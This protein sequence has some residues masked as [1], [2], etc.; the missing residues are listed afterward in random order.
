M[1]DYVAVLSL[2]AMAG[3][4]K[5][6]IEGPVVLAKNKRARHEYHI[7][8]VFEAGIV[9]GSSE[10]KSIRAGQCSITEAFG[11]I[12]DGEVWLMGMHV[13]EY[14]EATFNNHITRRNRKLLLHNAEIRKLSRKLKVSGYTLVPLD[15]HLSE[16]GF[17]K[18]NIA[19]CSGKKE[20]DKRQDMKKRDSDREMRSYIR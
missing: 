4:K 15:I 11:R 5:K 13:A 18:V 12:R 10:I 2:R 9:L 7:H 19:L 16:S 1:S 17:A 8:E 20:H 14:F 6:K 3:K